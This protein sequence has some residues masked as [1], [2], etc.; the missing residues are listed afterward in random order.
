[1]PKLVDYPL[2]LDRLTRE[3]LVCQYYNGGAFGFAK[4]T[5][6]EIRGWVGPEDQT[7]RPEMRQW[8][9]LVPEPWDA[10]LAQW[11]SHAWL[12][13]LPGEVWVMPAS[14]WSFELDHGNGDWLGPSLSSIDVDSERLVER[15]NA[16]AIEFELHEEAALRSLLVGLFRGL[17][18]SDFTMAFPGRGTICTLHHHKQLWW[19]T[20]DKLAAAALD[21]IGPGAV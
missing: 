5:K 11:A 6:V 4:G 7:I 15:T 12:K 8:V 16:A 20:A 19:Q 2:V 9:R 21:Q 1:M 17:K 18:A 14:H 13:V 3:G 10:T